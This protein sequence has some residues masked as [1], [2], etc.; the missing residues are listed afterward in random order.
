MADEANQNIVTVEGIIANVDSSLSQPVSDCV[1]PVASAPSSANLRHDFLAEYRDTNVLNSD[2][3][4]LQCDLTA[5]PSTHVNKQ[6]MAASLDPQMRAILEHNQKLMLQQ[7]KMVQALLTQQGLHTIPVDSRP[8]SVGSLPDS[9][10]SNGQSNT[11]PPATVTSGLDDLIDNVIVDR[12]PDT[13]IIDQLDT[14]AVL[15]SLKDFR[16]GADKCGPKINNDLALHV[17]DN[18]HK[19]VNEDKAKDLSKKYDRPE[20]CDSLFVPKTNESVWPSLKK[21]TQDL[22]AKLQRVQNFQL[23]AMYPN[24]QLFDELF[25]ATRSKKGMDH[26]ETAKCLN[27][28]KDTFQLLQVAFTDVSYR[29]RYLI[30]QD[31]KPSYKQLC[32][33]NNEITKN[34]LGDNI[35]T[36]IKEIEMSAKLSGKLK[37]PSDRYR[38][39]PYSRQYATRP[40]HQQFKPPSNRTH[41]SYPNKTNQST[42][43]FLWRGKGRKDRKPSQ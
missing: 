27:L 14:D 13:D 41:F 12:E 7:N 37:P 1:N 22:D 24:L 16:E 20:N 25:K 2:A 4:D 43:P 23:K 38:E 6:S 5:H 10:C 15:A 17:M 11:Q 33:D 19:R 8:P 29:R 36:K 18:F 32:N 34:L 28:A 40:T 21:R 35:D 3:I 26:S 39:K 31:L 42:Q 9:N 30:K